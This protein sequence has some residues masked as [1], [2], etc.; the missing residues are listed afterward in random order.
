MR[1]AADYR[2]FNTIDIF[3]AT[4]GMWITAVHTLSVA[5]YQLAAAS[6]PNYGLAIF[7]GG[8]GA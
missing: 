1:C 3:N 8:L 2:V 4:S 5:R 6:L 7:A